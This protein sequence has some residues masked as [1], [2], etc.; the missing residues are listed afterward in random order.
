MSLQSVSLEVSEKK[1]KTFR[2]NSKSLEKNYRLPIKCVQ[3]PSNPDT[4]QASAPVTMSPKAKDQ[5][6]LVVPTTNQLKKRAT[7][8]LKVSSAKKK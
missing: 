5:E 7:S 4:N 3:P 6:V 1:S 2:S 8:A